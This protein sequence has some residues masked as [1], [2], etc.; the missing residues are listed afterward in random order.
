MTQTEWENV[1]KGIYSWFFAATGIQTYWADQKRPQSDVAYSFGVLRPQSL[2]DEAEPETREREEDE[3]IYLDSFSSEIF[4]VN[5]QV[6]GTS[7]A[8]GKQAMA[9]MS[10]AKRALDLQEHLDALTAA[11]LTVV[12]ASSISNLSAV[13][14]AGFESRASMD[15]AFRVASVTQ[16]ENPSGYFNKVRVTDTDG[17]VGEDIGPPPEE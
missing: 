8:F 11:G 17:V 1:Q 5:C 2:V 4:T 15:V 3:D 6:F 16:A 13:A 9:I 10:K 7:Q 14:G 12:S